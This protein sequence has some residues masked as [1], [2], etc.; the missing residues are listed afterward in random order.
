MPMTRREFLKWQARGL[1]LAAGGPLLLPRAAPAQARP[2]VAVVRGR[3]DAAARAAVEMLGGMAAFVRSGQKVVIKP[4]MSFAHPPGQATTTNPLVVQAVVSMCREAGA[5]SVAV[6]DNT[7]N[8][9]ELCLERTGIQAACDPRGAHV[10]ALDDPDDFRETAFPRAQSMQSNHVMRAVLEADVLIA[11]P[12]AKHHGATG[13][14]LSMKGM[15]GLILDR[16][17][18]HRRH[19]L[20]TAI[21]DL[22]SFLTPALAVI[23]ASRVLTTNGPSGPG[24]VE[25]HDTVVASADMVAADAQITGMVKWYGRSVAP[26]QVKHIR[27]AHERGLGRMD[28]ENLSVRQVEI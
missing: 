3:P 7:L 15:M 21:V 22:C 8:S 9:A 5:S 6:V 20:Y 18:M 4:N 23:D 17:V 25:R 26:R 10:Q 24:V 16:G 14:S 1:A 13:V 19:D 11:V 27:L 28:V 2:D 12:V